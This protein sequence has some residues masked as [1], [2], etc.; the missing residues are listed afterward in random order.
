MED[1]S[2]YITTNVRW[3]IYKDFLQR[4]GLVRHH[5]D[6]FN[7]FIERGLKEIVT[8]LGV[9]EVPAKDPSLIGLTIEFEDISIGPPKFYE[10]EGNIVDVTPMMAR[11]R[12]LTYSVLVNAK[13][14]V[15][16]NG[17]VLYEDEVQICSLPVMVRSKIDPTSRMSKKE[18]IE[19]GEDWGDPGGYFI[20]NGS[21]RVIVAQEDLAPNRVF[22]E[23]AEL[24]GNITHS[25]KMISVSA[26]LRVPT[27][28][29]R[30][31]DGTLV[32]NF[33]PLLAKVPVVIVMKAL[34]LTTDKEIVYAISHDPEVQ[35]ELLPSLLQVQ[36]IKTREDALD[37]IGA[38][39][40]AGQV[41]EA[42]RKRAEEVLDRYLFPHVGTD[43]SPS[44]RLKKALYLGQM[45]NRLIE[46]VLGKREADDR[47]H[48]GNRRLRLAGD[49]LAQLFRVAFRQY[50]E[51]LKS[52][53]ERVTIRSGRINVRAFARPDIVT[54][55][56]RHA[57][58]TGNWVGGKTG[59]SQMLDR[60]NWIS[61]LS[62]LRRTVSPLSR[63]QPHFEAR[64]VHGTQFGRICLFE[65]PEGPN[66]GLVKNLAL[67]VKISAGVNPEEVL[68]ILKKLGLTPAEE[69]FKKLVNQELPVESVE[70]YAKVF[71]NGTLVGYYS[72]SAD[73]LAKIL[74]YMRRKGRLHPEV[75]VKYLKT[76]YLNEVYV[77]TD[78]GRTL[79]PLVVVENG[80]PRITQEVVNEYLAGRMTFDDLV[81][82][83][84]V[85][86]LDPDE[87]E[88]SYVALNP[89][90]LTPEH[91]HLEL[92]PPAIV[93]VAA[94]TIPY[95]EHNQSPR[96]TYQS[97][98]A[99]QA[100]GVYASNYNLRFDSRAHILHYPQKP[101][102]Q[103][104]FLDVIGYNG[105]PAG[106]N[107]VVAIL[108]YTG[109]NMEDAVIV[110]K[111]SVDRGLAR[112][113]FYREY[114]TEELRYAGG[115]MDKIEI[116]EPSIRGYRGRENYSLLDDDGIVSPEAKVFS[117]NV[118]V[119]KTSPPRFMEEYKELGIVS[120]TRRDTSITLRHG[121]RGVVDSAL[122]TVSAD[123]NKLVRVRVRDLRIPEIGD[124]FASRHGQK[125]VIGLLLPQYDMPYTPDGI[126]PDI[127]VNPHALPSRM[128]IGQLI[129][130]IAGKVGAL[131]GRL[132]DGT[133]FYGEKPD[134]LKVRLLLKGYPKEGTEPLYDG[135]TGELIT[136]PVFIGIVYYQR[137]H[138]MVADKIHSRARGPVQLLTRQP[139]EGR[140]REGGLRFGEMER[141][142]LIGHGAALLL[143]ER[144]LE[145]S[146]K[147]LVYVCSD[148]GLIG[149]FDRKKNR[150][151][152]PLHGDKERLYPV[153]VS[154]AFKLL[155]QE[156]MS[157]MIYPK[158]ILGDRYEIA[159]GR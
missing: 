142:C 131:E 11:L 140:A 130:S 67:Y 154:Y 103:T 20:I 71:L 94:A 53:L 117:G 72:G 23:K 51:E 152:C 4:T 57:L 151:V 58:A 61:M 106:Q 70:A 90:D 39:I 12:N 119:G 137:L 143:Q 76:E 132:V 157:M 102:V 36:E 98:M 1:A 18:L 83:G 110:N 139:T 138:H 135:R 14:V 145:S 40:A 25:A 158:L 115:Q 146:D 68:S 122:I 109:Y 141:D 5:I 156:L 79:R 93:G 95:L 97:A 127:I 26:G 43:S 86:F 15:K 96:N 116:P 24:S 147:V 30:L 3:E 42:R 9:I 44:V 112:S 100:L 114:L 108:S 159:G 33:P 37:Y 56:I 31:K 87:E 120:T 22:V 104:K 29:D 75:N 54:D 35:Q 155:L 59:V 21:E 8:S 27:I 65:T 81:R 149:W 121:D 48:Y 2:A 150:Y 89:E 107:F 129:E 123:G 60:T 134:E 66:C 45:I 28:V 85:E 133:P 101:I 55:R 73:S 17:S 46:L 64:D 136:N 91:T 13:V 49:L 77:N 128:T 124:K 99:K 63:G 82:R 153:K 50:I 118:L 80:K 52:S 144:M 78:E 10:V 47:D 34:G 126:T 88:N 6:S 32:I 19:I 113:T 16:R 111:S 125:G 38:R 69:V 7:N 148:C 92:W 41:A 105:R 62:H 84:Y 74:I